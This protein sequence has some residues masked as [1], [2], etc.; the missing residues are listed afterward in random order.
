MK[1]ELLKGFTMLMLIVALAFAT[2]VVSANAQSSSGVVANIPFEF[3][4]GDQA[5]PSGKYT[6]KATSAHVSALMIQNADAKRSAI[7]LTNSIESTKINPRAKLVFHRYGERYFLAEVWSGGSNSG[8]EL[9]KS[10]QERAIERELA[11]NGFRSELAQ[12]K[13]EIVEIV[14]TLH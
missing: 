8:R 4:V 6:I 10:R 2:A 9:V 13:Y 5:L 7:R 12:T 11:S 3:T 14:A 1:N